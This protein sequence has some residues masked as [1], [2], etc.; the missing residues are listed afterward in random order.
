MVVSNVIH[1]SSSPS[2]LQGYGRYVD[3]TFKHA[4]PWF[5]T[6]RHYFLH[7]SI[8]KGGRHVPSYPGLTNISW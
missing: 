8:D 1:D 5:W 6:F 7:S 2:M 3:D 4:A